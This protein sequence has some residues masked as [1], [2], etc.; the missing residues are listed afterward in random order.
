LASGRHEVVRHAFLEDFFGFV[1]LHRI[2]AHIVL[3]ASQGMVHGHDIGL[4]GS[5]GDR[6]HGQVHLIGA[7]IQRRFVLYDAH[8]RGFMGVEHQMG[9]GPQE[10]AGTLDGF[11]NDRRGGRTRSVLETDRI[12]RDTGIQDSSKGL[13][14]EVRIM[15]AGHTFWK[16]HKGDAHFM[17]RAGIDNGLTGIDKVVDVVESIEVSNRGDA[18]FLEEFRVEFDDV[19]ALGT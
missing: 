9:V 11:I 18:V 13:F 10:L 3:G 4:A 14:I 6:R 17:F 7:G 1:H 12:I 8:A 15:G 16:S 5:A 19:P 2:D